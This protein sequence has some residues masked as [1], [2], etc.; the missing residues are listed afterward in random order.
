MRTPLGFLLLISGFLTP[1]LLNFIC[2]ENELNSIYYLMSLAP[3]LDLSLN[4][5]VFEKV[6]P[7]SVIKFQLVIGVF[8]AIIFSK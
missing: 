6:N 7:K 5:L 8:S 4:S 2:G 1:F 3:F